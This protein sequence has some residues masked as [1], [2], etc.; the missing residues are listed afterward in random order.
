MVAAKLASRK[1]RNLLAVCA[2]ADGVSFSKASS[3]SL[4]PFLSG[5]EAYEQ[6][7]MEKGFCRINQPYSPE[8]VRQEALGNP[9]AAA[10]LIGRGMKMGFELVSF[11]LALWSDR[12]SGAEDDA[13]VVKL[14]AMQLRDMLT[15]LGPTFIKAG[16]V[17]ANRPDIMREDY[18]NEL[19]VLQDDVPSYSDA[20]AFA[21]IEAQLG[22][23]LGEVFSSISDR[24]IAAASLGQVYRAVLRDSGE[25]VAVKVQRPGVNPSFLETYSYSGP[26]LD[27]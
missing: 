22:R 19:C 11:A 21:M 1:R 15:R 10:A 25:D 24:P 20:E 8:L 23:P 27:Y 12:V 17:L 13:T 5:R 3:W 18:M 26:L 16:Q 4:I 9:A 6:L 14:R 7:Q 2:A